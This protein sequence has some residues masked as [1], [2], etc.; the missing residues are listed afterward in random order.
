MIFYALVCYVCAGLLWWVHPS[1]GV[2]IIPNVAE[3][4]IVDLA[5]VALMILGSVLVV[6]R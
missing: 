5:A 6:E 1:L 3:Y 4:P 2:L